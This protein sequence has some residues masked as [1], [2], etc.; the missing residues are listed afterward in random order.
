[1]PSN[2]IYTSEGLISVDHLAHHGVKGMKWGVRRYQNLDGSLN[3]KGIKKY[4][5]AGYAK[6]AMNSNK[7]SLG[8]AY[9]RFTGAHKN[10]ADI[11]Y[12]TASKKQNKERAEQYVRDTNK[13][14]RTPT[15]QKV[16]KTAAKGAV[17]T[18]Q[19]LSNV[20]TA[21]LA[22]QIFFNGTG[23]EIA[24]SAVK[25]AGRAAVSAWV[26]GH[27]GRDIHWYDN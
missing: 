24:K 23:T 20:G 1:M 26:Y 7:S 10:Y 15:K 19:I 22:D 25:N 8:R 21:Y 12:G 4:A 18:A 27:G 16:I 13:K 17:K 11:R 5:K 6:D 14:K 3:A 2:Y 9:D